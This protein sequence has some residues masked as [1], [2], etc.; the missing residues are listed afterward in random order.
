MV[1][2]QAIERLARIPVEIDVASEF[3]Y[4][5]PLVSDSHLA[6]V[7]SQSGETL[8]TL[9]ALREAR[10]KGAKVLAVV[11][12]VGSS[13]AREAAAVLYTW[14]GPEIAVASTKAYN[15]QLAALYLIALELAKRVGRLLPEQEAAAV[16]TL[17]AIPAALETIVGQKE[18][19]QR[20]A[21]RIS[22]PRACFSS[23]ADWTMHCPW[24]ARSSSRKSRTSTLKHMPGESSSTAP[25][26]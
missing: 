10:R 18:L 17:N 21:R 9:M 2:K 4:K 5:D 16:R 23:D 26:P 7:V 1:G 11:N 25:S 22:M 15:T 13:I 8:D 6:I 24:K 12:V 3:R 19:I 20:C 14:A